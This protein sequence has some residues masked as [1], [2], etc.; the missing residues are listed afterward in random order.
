LKYKG[1]PKISHREFGKMIERQGLSQLFTHPTFS[2]QHNQG[3]FQIYREFGKMI[4]IQG[5]PQNFPQGIWED[6]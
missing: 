2:L 6:D 3:E 1:Y 5:L 4:E